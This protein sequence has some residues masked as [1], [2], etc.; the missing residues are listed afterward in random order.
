MREG[1]VLATFRLRNNV[2]RVTWIDLHAH[3]GQHWVQRKELF[4][5]V[6]KKRRF[7]PTST[8]FSALMRMQKGHRAYAVRLLSIKTVVCHQSKKRMGSQPFLSP[9]PFDWEWF[10]APND[11]RKKVAHKENSKIIEI[12]DISYRLGLS[13]SLIYRVKFRTL[14]R[15]RI[16]MMRSLNVK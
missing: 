13:G 11:K 7:A 1:G 5:R 4:M 10:F 2:G 6:A 16:F 9:S 3:E 8:P 14:F 15:K 12:H